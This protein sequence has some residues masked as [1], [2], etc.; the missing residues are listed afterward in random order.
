MAT[1]FS[2]SLLRGVTVPRGGPLAR[3][4]ISLAYWWRHGRWPNLDAPRTFTEWVQWRKLSERSLLLASM[5]DKITAKAIVTARLGAEWVV[6]TLWSGTEAPATPPW[7]TP[8][9]IK[10]SHGCNQFAVVRD[11]ARDW[12][13]ALARSRTWTTKRY[14]YWLDEWL[15]S[16]SEPGLIVEPLIGEDDALPNDYKL[17]VFN[18]CAEVI[19]VHTDRLG[20]HRWVQYDRHWTRLSTGPEATPPATLRAMIAAAEALGQGHDFLRIDFYDTPR[21]PLFGEYCLYPGS[22][23]DPFEPVAL[24]EHLGAKW[25]D[26]RAALGRD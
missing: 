8:F 24:D 25:R 9:V 13:K 2:P 17:Y 3:L 16:K 26:A 22:G 19:Q 14:G 5:T 1:V 23:L 7:A 18:G 20:D 21:Q 11:I 12:P 15:Y 10:A 4:R 6:P